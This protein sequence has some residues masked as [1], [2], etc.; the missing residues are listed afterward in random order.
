MNKSKF[1]NFFNFRR[2]I[3]IY[4]GGLKNDVYLNFAVDE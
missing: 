3:L 4:T 1:Q 2:N